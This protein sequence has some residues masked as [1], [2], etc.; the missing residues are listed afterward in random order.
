MSV[1]KDWCKARGIASA[2]EAMSST[3][4]NHHMAHSVHETRRRDG[5][6]YPASSPVNIV[7]SI[8]RYLKEN[9]RPDVSFYDENILSMTT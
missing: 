4:I 3:D 2:I 6:E 8:Q 5:A 1:W 7:S 9:G